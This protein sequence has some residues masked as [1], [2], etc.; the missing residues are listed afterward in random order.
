MQT[1]GVKLHCKKKG[2]A[3]QWCRGTVAAWL[4]GV[5]GGMVCLEEWS[6]HPVCR[7]GRLWCSNSC[8]TAPIRGFSR[9]L[10]NPQALSHTG[11]TDENPRGVWVLKKAAAYRVAVRW[12]R[13][14]WE[15]A[16]CYAVPV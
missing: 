10:A 13:T 1:P 12:S 11:E 14:G 16:A 8:H 7:W 15:A 9:A 5:F 3:R 2:G 6:P 4:S